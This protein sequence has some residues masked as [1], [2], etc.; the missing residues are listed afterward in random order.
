MMTVAVR[1]RPILCAEGVQQYTLAVCTPPDDRA[2]LLQYMGTVV[3]MPA[4]HPRP[5]R[6]GPRP[7]RPRLGRPQQ[8]DNRKAA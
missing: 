6:D 7:C 5:I 3:G 8:E 1:S 2:P 4:G